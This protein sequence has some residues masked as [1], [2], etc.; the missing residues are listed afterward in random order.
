MME[1]SLGSRSMI[2]VSRSDTGQ[3]SWDSFSWDSFS[4]D[5]F[6]LPSFILFLSSLSHILVWSFARSI[7]ERVCVLYS[8][9]NV[10]NCLRFSGSRMLSH[11][12]I[13]S[14]AL[15]NR[16]GLIVALNAPRYKKI[17][18]GSSHWLRSHELVA[19]DRRLSPGMIVL[20]F[21][22]VWSIVSD[23]SFD[24]GFPS[25]AEEFFSFGALVRYLSMNII[26]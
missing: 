12:L 20:V 5:S 26:C 21:S 13:L 2:L 11:G 4:W 24:D 22:F 15:P 14:A 25:G 18:L 7:G 23:D 10:S 8:V 6:S 3:V 19:I 17:W 1:S 9:I 16:S